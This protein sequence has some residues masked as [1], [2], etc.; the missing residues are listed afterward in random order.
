MARDRGDERGDRRSQRKSYRFR[1]RKRCN[2]C[3]EKTATIDYKKP[4]VLRQYLAGVGKIRPRR[5]TGVCSKHQRRL[6]LAIKR[7]RHLALLPYT[8]PQTRG[9]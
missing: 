6:A 4:D 9:S 3:V 8:A 2:F 7:A 5:K 1:R